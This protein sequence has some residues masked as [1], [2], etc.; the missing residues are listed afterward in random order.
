M[1]SFALVSKNTRQ[2]LASFLIRSSYFSLNICV[3][4]LV[5]TVKLWYARVMTFYF[6]LVFRSHRDIFFS[7]TGIDFIIRR[8]VV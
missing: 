6:V 5:D 1:E 3:I 2:E 7:S 8:W 4:C